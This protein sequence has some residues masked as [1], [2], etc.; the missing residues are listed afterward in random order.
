MK[1]P[2]SPKCVAPS[3]RDAALPSRKS[4]IVR[5]LVVPTNK[6]MVRADEPDAVYRSA[7]GKFLAVV[8]IAKEKHAKGQPLL[9]GTTSIEKSEVLSML[10]EKEGV[11]HNVLN[12]KNHEREA[13]IVAQAGQKGSVTIA[14]NMAGRGTDIKLG[15][16]I[17]ALGGL[18]IL[19]TERHESRRI[20]NQLRGRSG[21][22]GDPGESRFFVSMEDD[23]MRL[24]GGDRLKS[25]MER[26]NV[27]ED[28]P[29]QNGMVSRSIESAQK[30][31]EGHHFDIRRHVLQ[32][33]DVMN[34]HRGLIYKRRQ[35]I[36]EKIAEA[37]SQ[38]A[39]VNTESGILNSGTD[40]QN[41]EFK[42]QI[43]SSELGVLHQD[44]LAS[45]AREAKAI[46][47]TH[48]QGNDSDTWNV[49]EIAETVAALHPQLRSLASEERLKAIT[50]RDA[51]V[52][53][54]T[55]MI[56][57]FYEEKCASVAA[58]TCA[59]AERVMTLRAIDV[60]WM[61]HIDD[62]SHL[63][64][65]VA[66]SGF[67][68]RDPLIEYQDQGFRRFQQLLN[69]IES[70]IVRTLLQI[71]FAQFAPMQVLQQ[72]QQELEGVVTN[73]A[74]IEG[75]LDQAGVSRNLP[76]EQAP[77]GGNPRV[78]FDGIK[79]AV[80]QPQQQKPLQS[81]QPVGRNDPCPCGSGKKYKKCHGQGA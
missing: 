6:P 55:K 51:L 71:D 74:Q 65:Q 5:T 79:A 18:C 64:E 69:T 78:S 42:L 68:Q 43:S 31:V 22:Q 62:M 52:E 25:M 54:V 80:R 28:V 48:A 47:E 29:L 10:L 37:E 9:I 14:T 19:G 70:T 38:Q 41:S 32:Y 60:H 33:D 34:K 76:I 11:P 66:F 72:A 53:F 7:K 50:D 21:R 36:L 77:Q 12:A 40:A 45:M 4:S 8:Q 49:K 46:V 63:R 24:F 27:P 73:E 30:R 67:A 26:L 17:A 20:D 61:D 1:I 3:A 56:H 23:L 81:V 2:A 57:D 15:E 16:G 75:A 39:N 13:E 44:V 58:S 35:K 59:M